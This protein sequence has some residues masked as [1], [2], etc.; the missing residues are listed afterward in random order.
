MAKHRAHEKIARRWRQRVSGLEPPTQPS[1]GTSLT[2]N[3][4]A[5]SGPLVEEDDSPVRGDS[6]GE[7]EPGMTRAT[8]AN[9]GRMVEG[10]APAVEPT[11][12]PEPESAVEAA[13]RLTRAMEFND[14]FHGIPCVSTVTR[15]RPIGVAR[16]N[17]PKPGHLIVEDSKEICRN[18][19][20]TSEPV[21]SLHF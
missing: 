6:T 15:R 21:L 10:A 17:T 18:P 1:T 11:G 9:S 14:S 8:S 13:H 2:C 7:A 12:D 19:T 5:V 3:T 4:I 16:E 20:G